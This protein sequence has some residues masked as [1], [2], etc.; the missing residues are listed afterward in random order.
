MVEKLKK[1][2]DNSGVGGMLLTN[3][4]KA[5]DCLRHDLLIAKLAAYGFDQPSLCFI[6][7][8]LSGRTWRTKVNAYSS[9]TDIKYAVPQGSILGRPSS[10]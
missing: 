9:Y 8:Y 2:L 7:S 6:F 10:F 5:F 1:S 4:S 3:L